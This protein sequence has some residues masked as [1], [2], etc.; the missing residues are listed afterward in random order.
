MRRLLIAIVLLLTASAAARADSVDIIFLHH[1]TG[2]CVWEGG[3]PAKLDKYNRTRGTQ[4]RISQREFPKDSPYG[5]ENY[6]FDYWNIWVKHAGAAPFKQEPT[7]E[8]LTPKYGVIVWKHCFPVSSVEEDT[9]SPD[10]GSADKRVENYKIQYAALKKKMLQFPK[11][12]F[13]VWTGAALLA[14]ETDPA[15]AKRAKA[16][17]DWVRATWDTPGDNIFVWDFRQLETGGG[18]YLKAENAQGDSHPN[19]TFSKRAA[20]LFSQRLV[21]VIEGRGDSGSK[22]GE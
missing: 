10:V 15:S 11:T 20:A 6:P 7:L 4:Y 22:T 2:G 12:K 21:D 5:W 19:A 13:V 9:G 3:V 18:L 1:S 14:G 17:F 8:M 16:F